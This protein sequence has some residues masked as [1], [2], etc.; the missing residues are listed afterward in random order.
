MLVRRRTGTSWQRAVAVALGLVVGLVGA[1]P[2]A[3]AQP[4]PTDRVV[5]RL[6]FGS[7]TA[8]RTF[9]ATRV[10][11]VFAEQGL[12]Q[13]DYEIAGGGVIEGGVSFLIWRNLAVG[14]DVSSYRSSNSAQLTSEVPHPFF[15]DLP[16]TTTSVAGGLVREELGVHVRGLWVMQLADWL[17]VSI[18]GGPSLFNVQQDLVASVEHAETGFPFEDIIFTGH[19]VTVQSSN[20][21]GVNGGIDIDT[22]VLHRLPFLNRYGVLERVGIGVMIRYVRGSVDALVVDTPVEVDL[23]GLQVTTGLRF[24]F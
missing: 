9:A 3:T 2:E 6:D 23:G 16:R 11:P 8:S 14:L 24:R 7:R 22:F 20:T 1:A 12:F 13:T 17:V 19:T 21:I 4:A 10:F 5:V 18:S 15:F